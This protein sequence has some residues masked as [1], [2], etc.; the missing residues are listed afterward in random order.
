MQDAE[1]RGGEIILVI[2]GREPN[3]TCSKSRAERVSGGV[4]TTFSEIKT[5]GL[6]YFTVECFLSF[7][8]RRP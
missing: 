2:A 8:G 5:N 1:E 7:N 3:V 4:D 6:R